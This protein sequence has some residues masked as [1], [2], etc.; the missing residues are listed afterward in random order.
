MS[1]FS[2]LS[3]F[4]EL[5]FFGSNPKTLNKCEL[6][7]LENELKTHNPMIMKNRMLQPPFAQ[8]LQV[9]S[10]YTSHIGLI[11]KDT[12]ENE[13]SSVAINYID[14]LISTGF[15]YEDCLLVKSFQYQTR[16]EAIKLAESEKKERDKQRSALEKVLKDISNS[17]Q[18]VQI[19][20]VIS[21]LKQLYD[22][23]TYD[24]R[25]FIKV[26]DANFSTEGD[27]YKPNFS[28][29]EIDL[30][31]Q[32]LLD[33]YYILKDFQLSSSV[34]RAVTVLAE[35][36]K[37]SPL[38]ED[39][40]ALIL[41]SLKHISAAL[42]IVS[43][44]NIAKLLCIIN[45]NSKYIAGA[46]TY[47]RAYVD[48]YV[49]RFR[50]MFMAD[51]QRIQNELKDERLSEDLERLFNGKKLCAVDGYNNENNEFLHK[52]CS[53]AFIWA[54]P[55]QI[56]KTFM[57]YYFTKGVLTLLND[58]VVDGLF[59]SVNLQSEFSNAVYSCSEIME[60]ITALEESF[61]Q[62]KD[63]DFSSI[64]RLALNSKSNPELSK[65][66]MQKMSSINIYVKNELH[67]DMNNFS[68]LTHFIHD[69]FVDAKKGAPEIA[70][71][72]KLLLFSARNKEYTAFL[73]SHFSL[74]RDFIEI[75]KNYVIF[76]DK[77]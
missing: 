56:L 36:R 30:Q 46:N 32:K 74:W 43:Y 15:S 69:M 38:T 61:G 22:I 29:V 23:C 52:T 14:L 4:L 24:Y 1:L 27:L 13:L 19:E 12:I 31:E 50:D 18:M 35:Q 55:L 7:K 75:M 73:E 34:A 28:P 10:Q 21:K 63:N 6:R 76:T 26:F 39:E 54:T 3:Y 44:E 67:L 25:K 59:S 49:A 51:E 58:I 57:H 72:I 64:S 62:G 40:K 45:N 20:E 37:M 71:N 70:S 5:L 33:L 8:A 66:L 77:E 68:K 48:E 11:L 53:Q 65:R 60:R 17:S 41:S 2:S 42:R 9:L 16:K 47:K